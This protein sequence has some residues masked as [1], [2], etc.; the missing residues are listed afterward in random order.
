MNTF[1]DTL[2]PAYGRDYKS[3]PSVT[4]DFHA[5]KDFRVAAQ[6]SYTSMQELASMGYDSAW[7]RY[8]GLNKKCLISFRPALSGKT[9]EKILEL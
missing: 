6:G 1:N 3:I 2:V 5:N 8:D 4:N 9:I 7:V